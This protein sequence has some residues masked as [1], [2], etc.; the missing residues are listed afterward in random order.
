MDKIKI[1]ETQYEFLGDG[2]QRP[3]KFIRR[4]QQGGNRFYFE[5][6]PDGKVELYSSATTLISDGYAEN[7]TALEVWRNTLRAEGKD[8]VKELNYT[9]SRGTLMHYLAS[10]YIIGVDINLNELDILIKQDAPELLDLPYYDEIIDRDLEWLQKAL[11]A[12]AQFV[13]EYEVKPLAT[14]LIMKSDVYKVASPIDL[15]AKMTIEEKGFFGE[16]YKTGEKKGT[17]KES[18]RKREIL[19]IIDL[20]SSQSGFYDSHYLQLQLYKRI[21]EENYP[22]LK[23]E[24]LFNWS[25]KDWRVGGV[26]T[27]NLKDQSNEDCLL[28]KLAEV[29]YQQGSIKHQHKEPTV[30]QIDGVVNMNNYSGEAITKSVKLVDYLE[31]FYKS[32][33]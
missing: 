33:K 2:L 19:A 22:D 27:Y 31:E 30:K 8:P 3:T 24:G 17:P 23:I 4:F 5:L 6:L 32:K 29:V 18:K 7:K 20:K 26:P 16:V 21:F 10:K 11:L 1:E 25:P 12:F 9:A 15:V 28:G 13:K 14:E